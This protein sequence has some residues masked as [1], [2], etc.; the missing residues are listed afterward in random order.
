MSS[1]DLTRRA[2]TVS[3]GV[4]SYSESTIIG[5]I[6]LGGSNLGGVSEFKA[7]YAYT[8]FTGNYLVEGDQIKDTAGNV[9]EVLHVG[10]WWRLNKFAG[11]Q[12]ELM[13]VQDATLKRLSYPAMTYTESTIKI[14][15]APQGLS[16]P[17][18]AYNTIS[19]SNY[20]AVTSA[21]VET[22]DVIEDN[23][24]VKYIVSA[25]TQYPAQKRSEGFC[26]TALALTAIS[27]VTL[28]T[29]TLGSTADTT[30]GHYPYS[31]SSSTIYMVMAPKNQ[32][33]IQTAAGYYGK[34]DYVGVT[35]STIHTDDKV[36]DSDGNTYKVTSVLPHA[37]SRSG[38]TFNVAALV[39]MDFSE[40]PTSSGTWHLDSTSVKTDPRDRI[41]TT[42]DTYLTDANVKLDDGA[43]E[44]STHVMFD[45][46]RYQIDRLFTTKDVDVVAVISRGTT[47][48]LYTDKLLGRKPYGFN[49]SVK[50]EICAVNKSGVTAT[51]IVEMY[52]Q[53]IRRVLTAY[54]PYANVR[55]LD[56]ISPSM[57]DLGAGYMYSTAIEVN[58]KRSNDDY[59]ASLPTITYGDTQASTYYFPNATEIQLRDPDTGDVILTPPGRAGGILQSLGTA[60]IEI[61]ITCDLDIDASGNKRWK[62]PQTTGAI[63]DTMKFQVF[64][65][66]K[67]GHKT[68][69]D[70]VFQNL[71]WGGGTTLPVRLIS[72]DV[73][74]PMLTLVFRRYTSSDAISGTAKAWYGIG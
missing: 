60:D 70:Q 49:E 67:W 65:D 25:S 6:Q 44:A 7:K 54:D 27:T 62:R 3:G 15:F 66:I 17:F 64:T 31:Y 30:T 55:D 58:Y 21:L 41:K 74:G 39:Q 71:N 61:E 35:A 26:Y 10:D 33:L 16:T 53:E 48:A 73:N 68:D 69:S 72:I 4:R 1:A 36:T 63:T 52:E 42:I 56:T 12:C 19:R 2:L 45:G 24:G 18:T 46:A 8:L 47:E 29:L 9:Y 32:S 57:V 11:F 23:T 43:T 13:L 51:R 22:G 14:A 59:T 40:D 38:F 28:G 50:I 34:Y 37:T 5:S 20:A